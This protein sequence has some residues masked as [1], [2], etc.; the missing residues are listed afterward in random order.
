MRVMGIDPGTVLT[1]FGIIDFQGNKFKPVFYDFIRTKSTSKLS[2]RY[3][4]IFNRLEEII[5]DYKPD[6]IAIEGQFVFKNVSSALKLGQAKGIV[7]LCSAKHNIPIYEYQPKDIKQSVTGRGVAGKEQVAVMVRLIL[8]LRA[9]PKSRDITDALA[10]AIC[11][12]N[13]ISNRVNISK[14]I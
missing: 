3:L 2:L 5:K 8:G 12:C 14:R 13:N 1:G 10:I 11:H 4:Q 7:V 9:V 6:S